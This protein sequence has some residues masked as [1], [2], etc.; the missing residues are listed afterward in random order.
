MHGRKR[1]VEKTGLRFDSNRS[2]ETLLFLIGNLPAA[3]YGQDGHFIV[4]FDFPV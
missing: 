2:P 4:I 1:L 3:D